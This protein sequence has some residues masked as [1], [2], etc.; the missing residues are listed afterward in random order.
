LE[1]EEIVQKA[2]ILLCLPFIA[3]DLTLALINL[4]M[5]ERIETVRREVTEDKHDNTELKETCEELGDYFG[6]INNQKYK[7]K[8]KQ[9][10][11]L[12]HFPFF[13]KI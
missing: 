3:F 6:I 12:L 11:Q 13:L 10:E 7:R 2:I 4:T 5:A 1:T 9:W 8:T